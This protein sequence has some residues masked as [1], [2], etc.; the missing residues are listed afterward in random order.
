MSDT[1]LWISYQR[2]PHALLKRSPMYLLQNFI[3]NS[4]KPI[5]KYSSINNSYLPEKIGDCN[6]LWHFVML[7]CECLI[8]KGGK[9]IW[10]I[11]PCLFSFC[12]ENVHP[13]IV[14]NMLPYHYK[15]VG[16]LDLVL[17][18][19]MLCLLL[20]QEVLMPPPRKGRPKCTFSDSVYC[21]T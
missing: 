4:F 16:L 5:N 13:E 1:Y 6:S 12:V 20:L 7:L 14:H 8:C 17:V 9:Y 18:E 15:S 2:H 10:I 3:Q 21:I 11:I 19:D